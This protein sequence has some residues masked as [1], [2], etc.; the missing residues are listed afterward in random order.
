MIQ[1]PIGQSHTDDC[2]TTDE[3]HRCDA[4]RQFG[5]PV[6]DRDARWPEPATDDRTGGEA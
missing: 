6:D 5:L 2:F 4:C 3:D 1:R